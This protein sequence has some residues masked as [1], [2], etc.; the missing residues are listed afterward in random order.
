[1]SQTGQ[2]DISRKVG[3]FDEYN[4]RCKCKVDLQ[5]MLVLTKVPISPNPPHWTNDIIKSSF[6]LTS[7]HIHALSTNIPNIDLLNA[8][9]SLILTY[10]IHTYIELELELELLGL[11]VSGILIVSKVNYV[12]YVFSTLFYRQFHIHCFYGGTV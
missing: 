8:I 4:L 6:E 2:F 1:M 7:F 10:T 3:K 11:F 5:R 9:I 12:Y